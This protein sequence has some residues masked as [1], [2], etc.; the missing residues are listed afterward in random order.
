MT[1][2][3]FLEGRHKAEHP[4]F[5]KVLKVLPKERFDYRPHERS[6]SAAEIVWTL[7][8]EAKACCELIDSGQ[9]KWTTQPPP[10]DPEAI[11]A[12]FQTHY[13]ALDERIASL[14]ETLAEQGKTFERRAALPRSSRRV[15]LVLVFRC[16]SS[17]WPV[18]HLHSADGWPGSLDLRSL[19]RRSGPVKQPTL[20]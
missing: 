1:L 11:L 8:R 4:A 14:R 9:V 6:P 19:R 17:P 16:D 15:P 5:V 12:A 7:A 2:R 3:E 13:A 20:S 10:T 18:K